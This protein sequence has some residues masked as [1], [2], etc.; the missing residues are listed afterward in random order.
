MRRFSEEAKC[1]HG[2]CSPRSK[3]AWCDLNSKGNILKLQHM[4]KTK[5]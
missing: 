3:G 2:H 1:K 5:M 4:S